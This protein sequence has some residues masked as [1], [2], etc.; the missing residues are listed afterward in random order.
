[1]TKASEEKMLQKGIYTGIIEKDENNN[2]FCGE[3][4]LDYKMV[5]AKHAVGDMI[6]IKSII[7]NPSDI[8]YNKYQKKSKN[9]DKANNKPQQ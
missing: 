6:T 3:Y 4:L 5:M 8:S 2:F 7:E 1:M 9:F